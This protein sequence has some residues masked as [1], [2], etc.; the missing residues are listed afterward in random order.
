MNGPANPGTATA[1]ESAEVQ[2]GPRDR[3]KLARLHPVFAQRIL[4]ILSDLEAV[5]LRLSVKEG[6]RSPEEQLKGYKAGLRLRSFS[7]HNLTGE[8]GQPEALAADLVDPANPSALNVPAALMLAYAAK[9]HGCTT[10]VT[11]GLPARLADAVRAAVASGEWNAPVRLG[12]SPFH[13]QPADVSLAA[14][15]AGK[16]PE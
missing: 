6:W 2:R 7:Y 5:G 13:V 14:A 1:V 8:R 11:W 16:R 3:D 15:R 9:N 4:A 12:W 10:G